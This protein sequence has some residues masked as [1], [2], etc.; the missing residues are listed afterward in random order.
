[1]LT[2]PMLSLVDY[3]KGQIEATPI[4]KGSKVISITTTTDMPSRARAFIDKEIEL[5]NLD[6]VMDKNLMATTTEKFI[7][8]RLR[9]IENELAA[10]EAE[11]ELYKEKNGIVSLSEESELLIKESTEYRRRIAEIETQLNLVQFVSDFINDDTKHNSLMPSNLGISNESLVSLINQYNA[12]LLRQIKVQRTA[13]G[14]NPVI[15]Q[16]ASQ[17]ELLRENLKVSID[18]V[19]K[20]LTISKN[21]LNSR[22][23]QAEAQRVDIPS[24]E[25]QYREVY[26][27]KQLKEE[28]YLFLYKQREENALHMLMAVKPARIIAAPQMNPTPVEPSLKGIILMCLILGCGF[29]FGVIILYDMLNNRISGDTKELEKRLKVPMAGVLVN[30]H[31]GTHIAVREG[32]NSVSAELFR[33]LRTNIQF[34][35]P[36]DTKC[37]ILLVTSSI[38]GEGKSYVATNLAISMALLGKKVALVGLDIRR[39]KLADYMNLSSQGCLTSYLSDT[40]Y[41]LEDTIFPSSI[42]N[43]DVIPAGIVP[44]NPSELLQSERLGTLFTAL[45]QRYDYVVVDTAPIAMVSDTFLLNRIA[46]MT[47]YV[48]RANYTTVDLLDLLNQTHLQQRLPKIVAVLN[49]VVAKKEYGY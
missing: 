45:R 12:L 17:L 35:H 38:N 25:R 19:R 40:A 27:N 32:E 2:L 44:P 11:V 37:P 34:L 29:P 10:A 3:Y 49:G 24:Q 42:S 21:D 48:T 22:F 30:N 23:T 5:Y 20:S 18:N 36:A 8:D 4:K 9:L 41:D 16:L 7:E 28:L 15:N 47:V 14:D 31:R 33:T 43:L 39:P 13:T 26:R 1:M 6:A 46:D